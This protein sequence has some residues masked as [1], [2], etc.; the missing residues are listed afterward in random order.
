MDT[1]DDNA[2]TAFLRDEFE[3]WGSAAER[4]VG[5][6]VRLL[7]SMASGQHT[8]ATEEEERG[9]EAWLVMQRILSILSERG[10]P[11]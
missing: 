11:I 10:E 8:P 2:P 4:A 9:R 3:A 6:N 1:I 5:G 7:L